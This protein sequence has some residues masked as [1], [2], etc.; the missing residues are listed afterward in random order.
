MRHRERKR[1]RERLDYNP[2]VGGVLTEAGISR[3]GMIPV[4]P[5][6]ISKMA[7]LIYPSYVQAYPW[8]YAW[9]SKESSGV[10]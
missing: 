5:D 3:Y 8:T 1:E 6:I 7:R 9:T 2:F 4:C 10:L